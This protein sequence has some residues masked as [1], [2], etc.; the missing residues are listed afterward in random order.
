MRPTDL[1]PV[2]FGRFSYHEIVSSLIFFYIS[3]KEIV[4]YCVWNVYLSQCLHVS[5]A[6]RSKFSEGE[7]QTF[8][9]VDADRIVNLCNS[10]HDMWRLYFLTSLEH[11]KS[12]NMSV[13]DQILLVM[14]ILVLFCYLGE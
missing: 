14:P 12:M 6:E 3:I 9:S 11:S 7:I 13:L 2:Q 4:I 8:M 1:I 5:L 10:V